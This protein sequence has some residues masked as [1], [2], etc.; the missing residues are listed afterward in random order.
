MPETQEI[1]PDDRRRLERFFPSVRQGPKERKEPG[2]FEIALVLAGGISAG[3]YTAGV[4]DYLIEALDEWYLRKEADRVASRAKKPN[5]TVPHHDVIVRIIAGTS[6][7]GRKRRHCSV[8]LKLCLSA[9]V[10]KRT[11]RTSQFARA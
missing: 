8:A 2:V 7:G 3:A 9:R 4:M 11:A 1:P 6:A 5:Q 10:R